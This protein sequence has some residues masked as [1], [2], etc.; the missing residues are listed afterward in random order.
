MNKFFINTRTPLV[1][2]SVLN[3]SELRHV[4]LTD[5][6][7]NTFSKVSKL[8]SVLNTDNLETLFKVSKLSVFN[9]E[10]CIGA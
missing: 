10:D 5:K 8:S 1:G 7:I 3:I 9:K 4:W 6:T 2:L